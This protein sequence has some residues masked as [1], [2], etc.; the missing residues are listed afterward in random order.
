MRKNKNNI[1]I[2]LDLDGVVVDH[3]E[4]RTRLAAQ[5]GFSLEKKNTTSGIMGNVV[6]GEI[7]RVIQRFLYREPSV[8]LAAPLMKGAK[9]GLKDLATKN[10]PYMLI[11]RRSSVD[12]AVALLQKHKIWPQYFHE[13]NAHFV[14]HD[15]DKAKKMKEH[16]VTVYLDDKPEVLATLASVRHRFLFDPHGAHED[17][18][19]YTRVSSWKEF[20]KAVEKL[21][22]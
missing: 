12:M 7:Y 9:E 5:F 2:G 17:S 14:S 11:S 1:V 21:S 13:K 20:V 15:G 18:R 19:E 3:T 22:N 4:N 10:I 6:P 8:A 16:G